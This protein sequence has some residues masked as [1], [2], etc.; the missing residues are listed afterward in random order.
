MRSTK[1]AL[2]DKETAAPGFLP[3]DYKIV[4]VTRTLDLDSDETQLYVEGIIENSMTGQK[5]HMAAVPV[6][7]I[8]KPARD[9]F[10]SIN[11]FFD[12]TDLPGLQRREQWGKNQDYFFEISSI[13]NPIDFD[14]LKS[15]L[16]PT[17]PRTNDDHSW[18]ANRLDI[19]EAILESLSCLH[20]NGFLLRELCLSAIQDV[21]G[22]YVLGPP[23]LLSFLPAKL[24]PEDESL[25]F[26]VHASPELAG[27][28]DHEL[29]PA[30]DLYSLGVILFQLLSG[31]PPYEGQNVGSLLLKHVTCT[32]DWRLIKHA[33]DVLIQW[34]ERLL[35][36][37][38]ADRYQTSE[39]VLH[40]LR[41]IRGA[42]DYG[43]GYD[44]ITLG[45]TDKRGQIVE[46][47]FVGRTGQLQFVNDA[48]RRTISGEQTVLR[49]SADSGHGKSRFVRETIRHAVQRGFT[50]YFATVKNKI[51]AVP[52]A[53]LEEIAKQ[54]AADPKTVARIENQLLPY[55]E[56][57]LEVLPS[58]AESFGWQDENTS[59]LTGPCELGQKRVAKALCEFLRALGEPQNPVVI[60]LDDCQWL[61]P[62]TQGAIQELGKLGSNH[63]LIVLS[64][65]SE[66]PERVQM[67]D[68]FFPGST[69]IQLGPL[70]DSEI[71]E[72]IESMAGQLPSE[73]S[74]LIL[75]LSEGSPFMASAMLQGMGETGAIYREDDQWKVDEERM[76]RLQAS[77]DA[78]SVLVSRIEELPADELDVLAA[79][80]VFGKEFDLDAMAEVLERDH[81]FIESK[82]NELR[83]KKL[84]WR[85]PDGLFAFVHNKIRETIESILTGKDRRKLHQKIATYIESNAPQN[86]NEIA[87]HYCEAGRPELALP[88]AIEAAEAARRKFSLPSAIELYQIADRGMQRG[89]TYSEDAFKVYSGL[90]DSLMLMGHYA[91]ADAYLERT[92]DFAKDR[93][94]K[95]WVS[96]KGGELAFKRGNKSKSVEACELAL[97][98]LGYRVPKGSIAI[99]V[100][101]LKE[102]LVQTLHT[103]LPKIFVGRIKRQPGLRESLI[104]RLFS[105]LAHG[106]WYTSTPPKILWAHLRGMNIAEKFAPSL[107]LAQAHSEHGPALSLIL[108]KTRGERF[109]KNALSIRKKF[110]SVWGQGQSYSYHAILLYAVSCYDKSISQ[111]R[112]AE[113]ILE[114]TG[115]HWE[116]NIAR[117]H[118]AASLYHLGD[119]SSA[120]AIAKK[121]YQAAV[122][123]GDFQAT[124]SILDIWARASN[125]KVPQ[126]LIDT[127]KLR[128]VDDF[129]RDCHMLL[130]EGIGLIDRKEYAEAALKFEEANQIC[131][132]KGLINSYTSPNYTWLVRALR[133]DLEHNP[134]LSFHEKRKSLRRLKRAVKSALWVTF[135]FRNER[136]LACLEY[137]LVLDM[138]G[139]QRK[140]QAWL[141]KGMKLARLSGAK[142]I[143]EQ[144]QRTYIELGKRNGWLDWPKYQ[145]ALL[146]ETADSEATRREVSAS[147]IDLFD[148]LLDSGRQVLSADSPEKVFSKVT[149]ASKKLLRGQYAAVLYS[150]DSAIFRDKE[151][152]SIELI[153]DVIA[154]NKTATRSFPIKKSVGEGGRATGSHLCS[155]ILISHQVVGMLYV[156]NE[157]VADNFCLESIR[158]ADYL[159]NAAGSALEKID[160]FRKLADLNRQL[161]SKVEDRTASL[162]SRTLDLEKTASA[163]KQT[164][165]RLVRAHDD[166]Q[167]ANEAKSEFLARM[168]HEM[169]TPLSAIKGFTE[170]MLRGTI[171]DPN[172]CREKLETIRASSGHLIHLINELLDLTKVEA[173]KLELEMM[174]CSP[175][176]IVIETFESLHSKSR[177]QGIGFE[178][179]FKSSIPKRMVTDPTRLKQV[180]TNLLGNALKFSAG[181]EVRLEVE[182]VPDHNGGRSNVTSLI[183]VLE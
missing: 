119:T 87:F 176:K 106:Y 137:G 129:Q 111:A 79:S 16:T 58:L 170:L 182:T 123:I 165:V 7:A 33:P 183:Q 10:Q 4:D 25:Q 96:M 125:G 80:S 98:Q 55:R 110:N 113:S 166:A 62:Q 130:A 145:V 177:E 118:I 181:G 142:L 40:D 114:Q 92:A 154:N 149:E 174:V 138:M 15:E 32:P 75:R 83:K 44:L 65:R 78:A 74:E 133:L 171:A 124:G 45:R 94:Q 131:S 12:E 6:E 105:K 162:R 156:K 95:A 34:L 18:L 109:C 46:P 163:L 72:L 139:R 107:E 86:R 93:D 52:G 13:A 89:G 88:F 61:D 136:P 178:F 90:A 20:A 71:T 5:F 14:S 67:L 37:K 29:G 49:V 17:F 159:A 43:E 121:T 150:R 175:A 77:E 50:A 85:R 23:S 19:A 172:E 161:E 11:R 38:P 42:I 134:P 59:Q 148:T 26:A 103:I 164:Q 91:E 3:T 180:L 47:A 68:E 36:K 84:I 41:L 122:E 132:K 48:I 152:C 158:I 140:A 179:E 143:S 64:V 112:L 126:E 108:W 100:C 76:S 66:N 146:Q 51:A 69:P 28:I 135:R 115:D 147:V 117:Y 128:D 39:A 99:A 157:L 73:V 60:W 8:S 102:I 27:T 104:L 56:V 22:R 2:I 160:G 168:S 153:R 24:I 173:D 31:Q 35:K 120:F 127:E 82:L 97:E 21:E 169:R 30:S 63:S 57:I 155:P 53:P 81:G 9:R 101:L 151:D 144:L 141:R 1:P 70:D 167:R 116:T 54:V